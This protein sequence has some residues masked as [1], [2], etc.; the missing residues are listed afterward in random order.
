LIQ[1]FSKV[2][3]FGYSELVIQIKLAFKSRLKKTIGE[4]KAKEIITHCKNEG[5]LIQETA[6]GKYKRGAFDAEE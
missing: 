6:K 2:E 3:E 4:N 5:W 1:S